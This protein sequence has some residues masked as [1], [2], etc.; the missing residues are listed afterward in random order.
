MAACFANPVLVAGEGR[1]DTIVMRGLAGSVFV[2]G[3]AEGVHCAALPELGIGIAVKIDDGAKR[4]AEMA[5][6]MLLASFVAGADQ[7]L[8]RELQGEIRNWRGLKVGELRASPALNAALAAL[9]G[10]K[11]DAAASAPR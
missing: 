10:A 4:A 1:F 7:V 3:G 5:F 8:A 2:K 11:V 9:P 6:A